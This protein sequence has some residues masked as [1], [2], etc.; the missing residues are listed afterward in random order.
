VFSHVLCHAALQTAF[1]EEV[2]GTQSDASKVFGDQPVAQSV[3]PG[4]WYYLSNHYAYSIFIYQLTLQIKKIQLPDVEFL[5]DL[6]NKGSLEWKELLIGPSDVCF[7]ILRRGSACWQPWWKTSDTM[8]LYFICTSIVWKHV[9]GS[10]N[11]FA[12]LL[13]WAL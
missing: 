13:E 3:R 7:I 1:Q 10:L 9:Y 2:T 11:F 4:T 5:N 8:L 6:S 12:A